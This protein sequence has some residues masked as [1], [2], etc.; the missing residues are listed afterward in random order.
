MTH[1]QEISA[2]VRVT[3]SHGASA[4]SGTKLYQVDVCGELLRDTRG[5]G[6]RFG[7][8]AAAEKAGLREYVRR[9]VQP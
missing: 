3:K 6:R 2:P 7:T 8:Y 5:V 4:T 9:R 1:S